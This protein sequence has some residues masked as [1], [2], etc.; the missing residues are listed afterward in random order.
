MDPAYSG[1]DKTLPMADL[2]GVVTARTSVFG[3][4]WVGIGEAEDAI[5]V[6][7]RYELKI[8]FYN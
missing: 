3:S 4:R 7:A 1:T 8:K 5:A 6:G 2:A